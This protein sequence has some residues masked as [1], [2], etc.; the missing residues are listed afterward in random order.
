MPELPEVETVRRVLEPQLAGRTVAAL[1][2]N[3]PEI[4]A[5]PTAEQFAA[6]VIGEKITGMGRRGKYLSLLLESGARVLLHL[7]MTGRLLVTPSD[8]LKEKHTH[9]VFRLDNGNELRFMDTRRF[10]RFWLFQPGEKDTV[11]GASKLGPEPFDPDFAAGYLK[12]A[13]GKRRRSI[14]ECLLDQGVV[15]GIGNIYG[16][17]ILFAARIHPARP[18]ASLTDGEWERLKLAV[19]AVLEK[20]IDGNRTTPEEYLKGGGKEYR[21]GSFL[22]VYGRE[23]HP[24]PHCGAA[25]Q[26][27]ALAGRSSCYCPKCQEKS[28][29]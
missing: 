14:K 4:V 24:C 23:G 6:A 22:Q 1:I 29:C 26:R 28:P 2:V 21:G 11:S 20:G 18:A 25:F 13:L 19:P 12:E 17:E 8:Y 15:A 7:R 16:D 3:R 9:M 10:G 27:I 5:H